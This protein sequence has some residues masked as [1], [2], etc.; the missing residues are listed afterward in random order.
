VRTQDKG[1]QHDDQGRAEALS[2]FF[3]VHNSHKH[4][5]TDA[6]DPNSTVYGVLARGLEDAEKFRA[7]SG[8]G[9]A[10]QQ[11][12]GGTDHAAIGNLL[13]F[14]KYCCGFFN[15]VWPMGY[16]DP[17]WQAAVRTNGA[18]RVSETHVRVRGSVFAH[19]LLR[20]LGF[21]ITSHLP[22]RFE[23][24]ETVR[25]GKTW[26]EVMRGFDPL[27]TDALLEVLQLPMRWRCYRGVAILETEAF[28]ASTNSIPTEREYVIE[29]E[30]TD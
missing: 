3:I 19:Q 2:F 10:G 4:F 29:V 18:E 13:G 11:G 21:R 17:I 24:E 26:L 14:P 7:A 1:Y 23:C 5:P 8:Y 16:Y 30:A 15:K 12:K 27:G 20:Y 9:E 28:I 25:V 22:C 6:S